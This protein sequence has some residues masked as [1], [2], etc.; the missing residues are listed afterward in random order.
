MQIAS[1]A[2][3][4]DPPAVPARSIPP[5]TAEPLSTTSLTL[6]VLVVNYRTWEDT[7]TLLE[8]LRKELDPSRT[9]ILVVNNC[10]HTHPAEGME[11]GDVRFVESVRNV[12]FAGGVN[13]G[14]ACARGRF[15]LL[16]NPDVRP[17]AGAIRELLAAA[18]RHA[19]AGIFL[20]RLL[21]EQ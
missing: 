3:A 2:S 7:A 9:E 19:R 1:L 11:T 13:L 8:S 16:L 17:H 21:D 18:E 10:R 15:L 14:A 5:E 12:G 20:P 6:S 4:F